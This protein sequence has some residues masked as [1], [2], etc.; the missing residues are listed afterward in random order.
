M[1]S[2]ECHFTVFVILHCPV[3]E[4]SYPEQCMILDLSGS[5]GVAPDHSLMAPRKEPISVGLLGLHR[6]R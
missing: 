2:N 1:Y 5:S 3:D 6:K 4:T